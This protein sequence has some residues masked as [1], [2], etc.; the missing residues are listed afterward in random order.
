MGVV[1]VVNELSLLFHAVLHVVVV[2]EE[3]KLTGR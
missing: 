3:A 2:G 1:I